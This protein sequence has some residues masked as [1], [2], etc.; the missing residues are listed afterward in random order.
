MKRLTVRLYGITGRLPDFW[1][2]GPG[3]AS[4]LSSMG[5]TSM[6]EVA[7]TWTKKLLYKAFGVDAEYLIDHSWEGN[8]PPSRKS[9]PINQN[10]SLSSGQVLF[11][12]I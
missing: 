1:R 8:P 12:G 7:H 6:G 2:I 9:K 5:I 3:I 10:N 4:R 11:L